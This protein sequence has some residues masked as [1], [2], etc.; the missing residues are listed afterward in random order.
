MIS[1]DGKATFDEE[2][3]VR[4]LEQLP[5]HAR[6]AFASACAERLR[7]SYLAFAE[8]TESGDKARAYAELLDRLWAD[9]KGELMPED[10]VQRL[11]EQATALIP[12]VEDDAYDAYAEDAA[13]ALSY[14]WGCRLLVDSQEAAWA[15][16]RAYE[17]VDQ[18]VIRLEGIDLAEPGVE[19]RILEHPLIQ[20]E[21]HRQAEDL[22]DLMR[23]NR[24]A[25]RIRARATRAR[26]FVAR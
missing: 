22:R 25:A 13:A 2:R 19:R 12:D 23:E 11:A 24:N 18:F 3:L 5:V 20:A 15:A 26:A 10:D 14:A 7:S 16:R 1:Q 21:L 6:V 4:S 9:L 8:S 17:A